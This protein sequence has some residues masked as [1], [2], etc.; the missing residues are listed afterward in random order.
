VLEA[1]EELKGSLRIPA[2][3]RILHLV[4]LRMADDRPIA[5]QAS[6]ISLASCLGLENED[7]KDESLF[8]LLLSTY[9]LY[10]TWTEVDIQAVPA[11]REEAQLLEIRPNDPL[12]VVRGKTFTDSFE[13]IETVRTT[14]IGKG[15]ALYIG[16]QRIGGS[17]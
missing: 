2:G 15:L 10:P 14:Y 3:Q 1:D 5:L 16:R 11:S 4:R 13:P 17:R 8:E 6:Y 7:L 9:Y 12:L